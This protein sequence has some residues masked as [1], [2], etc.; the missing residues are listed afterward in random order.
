MII[1]A[2][3]HIPHRRSHPL[4]PRWS[5]TPARSCRHHHTVAWLISNSPAAEINPQKIQNWDFVFLFLHPKLWLPMFVG[6]PYIQILGHSSAL[7]LVCHPH[8][9]TVIALLSLSP[10]FSTSLPSMRCHP[11]PLVFT[12]SLPFNLHLQYYY[13]E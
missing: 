7:L 2:L 9:S 5:L 13:Y 10:H 8:V 4:Q 6:S 12:C 1:S 11:Y 3:S